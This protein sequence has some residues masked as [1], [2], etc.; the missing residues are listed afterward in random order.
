MTTP[1]ATHT[2]RSAPTGEWPAR[3][4]A[5]CGTAPAGPGGILCPPCTTA[6]AAVG[7]AE[8]DAAAR[9]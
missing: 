6:I 4:C 8:R 1:P 5:K 7:Q 9:R 3:D 2:R